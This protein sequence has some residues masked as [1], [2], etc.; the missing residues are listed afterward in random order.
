MA[1][2]K[3]NV[4]T[5]KANDPAYDVSANAWNAEHTIDNLGIPLG[6]LANGGYKLAPTYT[7][8]K[9]GATTYAMDADGAVTSNANSLTI[10]QTC[11]DAVNVAG[12][13]SVFVKFADYSIAGSIAMKSGVTLILENGATLTETVN[14]QHIVSFAGTAPSHVVDAHLI[15]FG[16]GTV[17]GNASA[18][19][20]GVYFKYTERCSVENIEIANVGHDGFR[21]E[22]T[23]DS[24]TLKK[25]YVHGF[26]LVTADSSGILCTG[27]SAYRTSILDCWVDGNSAALA[28]TGLLM[29]ATN[30]E[31]SRVI[32]G[33]FENIG[34]EHGVYLSVGCNYLQAIGGVSRNCASGGI[35]LNGASHCLVSWNSQGCAVGGTLG[36]GVTTTNNIMHIVATGCIT[37]F[38]V[39]FQNYATDI[40]NNEIH[41]A[42]SG[43]TDALS[44][45]IS[46]NNGHHI[47]YNTFFVEADSTCTDGIK[48]QGADA[49][50]EV[51]YNNF[52]CA[53]N[54]SSYGVLWS[55]A[56]IGRYNDF[57]G[58]IRGGT[59][60]FRIIGVSNTPVYPNS[61]HG[62]NLTANGS[63]AIISGQ[64]HVHVTHGLPCAPSK[65]RITPT[66]KSTA[67][68][69]F[70]IWVDMI[71]TAEFLVNCQVD[72]GVLTLPFLWEAEV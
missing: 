4:V 39:N 35:Q 70:Y 61:F 54:A 23:N 12:G 14:S 7:I 68:P 38:N 8:Y 42:A 62:G 18:T 41:I 53:V 44:F 9:S 66:A 13:G 45:N 2:I 6:K 27:T 58:Q 57:Q 1:G 49:D 50:T 51:K 47:M 48:I 28:K 3:H 24:I 60:S 65:I 21:S 30:G 43:A 17:Y 37:G 20:R 26:G 32:G 59:A 69:T 34:G 71:G 29:A 52:I 63:S 72:P 56:N 36:N 11:I 19:E 10:I 15:S 22:N 31:Y 46:K 40:W 5:A 16:Q 55:T 33:L 25:L 64:T 67:D